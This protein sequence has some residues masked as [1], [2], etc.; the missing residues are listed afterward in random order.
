MGSHSQTDLALE[1]G[2]DYAAVSCELAEHYLA[3]FG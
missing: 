2:P 3:E 1:L